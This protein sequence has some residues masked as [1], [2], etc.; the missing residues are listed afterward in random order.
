MAK[1]Y[2]ELRG[3]T[4]L[5]SHPGSHLVRAAPGARGAGNAVLGGGGGGRRDGSG[6]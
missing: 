2:S 3:G 4:A 6:T 5:E 1:R